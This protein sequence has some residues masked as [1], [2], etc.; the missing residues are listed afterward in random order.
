MLTWHF[1]FFQREVPKLQGA[2][3]VAAAMA[4][5]DIN[6]TPFEQAIS[7][8][9]L[10]SAIDQAAAALPATAE[11]LSIS[12]NESADVQATPVAEEDDLAVYPDTPQLN[13]EQGDQE[14]FMDTPPL[15]PEEPVTPVSDGSVSAASI[16]TA[17]CTQQ[18]ALYMGSQS[19]SAS[20][21]LF[22]F[23][24]SYYPSDLSCCKSY[25]KQDTNCTTA[26]E[27]F[28]SNDADEALVSQSPVTSL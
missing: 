26:C 18:G 12:D 21:I 6:D 22:R 16:N 2:A 23:D 19:R 28:C 13:P 24:R 3:T 25:C 5:A 27:E 17:D 7:E 11:D 15:N 8:Q 20:L 1:Y 9:D 10:D 4:T 14:G